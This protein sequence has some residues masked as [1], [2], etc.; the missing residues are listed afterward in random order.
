MQQYY[1]Q[2]L[3]QQQLQQHSGTDLSI[4]SQPSSEQ[5][6]NSPQRPSPQTQS[7]EITH[8]VPAQVVVQ[9]QSQTTSNGLSSSNGAQ[10][11]NGEL[12]YANG[13]EEE[14]SGGDSLNV[15]KE[16]SLR[17]SPKQMPN[18][19]QKTFDVS[20]DHNYDDSDA[21]QLCVQI[22]YPCVFSFVHVI[23]MF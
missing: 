17:A 10:V 19:V 23:I 2:Q 6:Q 20:S 21:S 15:Q 9:Q 13:S 12:R 16:T 1:S 4:P 5:L 3:L 22:S 18:G 8:P 11:S 7:A 14:R